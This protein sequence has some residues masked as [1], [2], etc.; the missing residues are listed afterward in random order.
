MPAGRK[1]GAHWARPAQLAL[2]S[3]RTK[4]VMTQSVC[5][6]TVFCMKSWQFLDVGRTGEAQVIECSVH[7]GDG[8]QLRSRKSSKRVQSKT[9]YDSG[10][11][12]DSE[13][14]SDVRKRRSREYI[15]YS[16]SYQQVLAKAAIFVVV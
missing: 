16:H 10:Q 8:G 9:I 14:S 11:Q 2:S 6:M 15:E 5:V 4:S 1:Y 13:C 12:R 7:A 3:F